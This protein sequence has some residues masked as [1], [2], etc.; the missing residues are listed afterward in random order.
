MA[1]NVH[2]PYRSR[3]HTHTWSALQQYR[4]ILCKRYQRFSNKNDEFLLVMWGYVWQF[5]QKSDSVCK[6]NIILYV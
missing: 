3:L 6:V 4:G 2:A 1:L 5:K